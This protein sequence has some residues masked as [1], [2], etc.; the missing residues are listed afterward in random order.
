MINLYLMLLKSKEQFLKIFKSRLNFQ[1]IGVDYGRV[2]TG[3]AIYSSEVNMVLHTYVIKDLR[4]NY[5]EFFKMP[6]KHKLHGIVVGLPLKKTGELPDNFDEINEVCEY[7]IRE[8][9]L[10]LYLSDERYTSKLASVLLKQAN[11]SRK[12]RSKLNDQLSASLILENLF[13]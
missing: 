13:Y 6:D 2:R 10:P 7:L 8:T 9:K 4:N 1:I 11:K 12:Q 5:A 3:V